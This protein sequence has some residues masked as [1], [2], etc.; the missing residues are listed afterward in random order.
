[1]SDDNWRQSINRSERGSGV[2][3]DQPGGPCIFSGVYKR[4]A[5]AYHMPTTLPMLPYI[6]VMQLF[7]RRNWNGP[8]WTISA[9]NLI[10]IV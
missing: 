1:M 2:R 8:A 6:Q 10:T 5:R 4:F 9:G 3:F 7:R